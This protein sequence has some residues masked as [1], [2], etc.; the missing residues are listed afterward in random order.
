MTHDA[1]SCCVLDAVGRL[2]DASNA[3]PGKDTDGDD[4]DS[5]GD[6][7]HYTVFSGGASTPAE[8]A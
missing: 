6:C 7:A 4:A 5:W 8:M 3:T 1:T 2:Q